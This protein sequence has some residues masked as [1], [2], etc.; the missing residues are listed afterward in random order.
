MQKIVVK[1][2]E[3]KLSDFSRE[4]PSRDTGLILTYLE[5]ENT[6]CSYKVVQI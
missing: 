2:K 1:L 3:N 6:E 4:V 5:S